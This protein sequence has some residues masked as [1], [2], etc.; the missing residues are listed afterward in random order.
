MAATVELSACSSAPATK[1]ASAYS[2]TRRRPSRS[3]STDDSGDAASAKSDV[4]DVMTDLSRDVSVR[5]ESDVPMETS[6]ADITP[7]SSADGQRRL[8]AGLWDK[9]DTGRGELAS[10]Q[11][12]ADARGKGQKQHEKARLRV[13]WLA[14]DRIVARVGG[15]EI[16]GSVVV[17]GHQR[18]AR[19]IHCEDDD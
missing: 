17:A 11:Q 18:R 3:A 7:V 4:D 6:V 8:M 2:S 19:V 12:P 1:S 13:V 10:E 15:F 5:P 16:I 14:L 9:N